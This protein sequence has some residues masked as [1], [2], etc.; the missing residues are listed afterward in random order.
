MKNICPN[1]K[2][3][4]YAGQEVCNVCHTVLPKRSPGEPNA[5]LPMRENISRTV[6]I[7]VA[8][9]AVGFLAL[10][11]SISAR[12]PQTPD[13]SGPTVTPQA[14]TIPQ[15]G[16]G[17][18]FR[19][20]IDSL[21]HE[22]LNGIDDSPRGE[23]ETAGDYRA[24]QQNNQEYIGEI[25]SSAAIKCNYIVKVV[26]GRYNI[27]ERLFHCDVELQRKYWH[28]YDGPAYN[29]EFVDSKRV[30]TGFYADI[31]NQEKR[32]LTF[33]FHCSVENAKELKADLPNLFV[34]SYRT[35]IKKGYPR[36][37]Q[38]LSR[39][40]W[41]SSEEYIVYVKITGFRIEQ[42]KG[43]GLAEIESP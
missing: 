28:G 7:I 31:G 13:S 16:P 5:P 36:S 37:L 19:E 30:Q 2:S 40:H 9:I 25:N 1:C 21:A 17:V 39:E 27:D 20:K 23:F 22:L 33:T 26:S 12:K 3:L 43:V 42:Q 15:Y 6:A 10:M 18:L 29:W 32:H 8:V 34:T 41:K 4:C 35:F 38:R 11:I 24:R 14:V